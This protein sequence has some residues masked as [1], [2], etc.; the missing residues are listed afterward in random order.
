MTLIPWIDG[1][2]TRSTTSIVRA[3]KIRNQLRVI[4]LFALPLSVKLNKALH[5]DITDEAL[6]DQAT[7]TNLDSNTNTLFSD[8]STYW[9]K[10]VESI[11]G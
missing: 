1:A 5:L 3:S 11:L 7:V 4:M 8:A 2:I 9:G 10:E 6:P